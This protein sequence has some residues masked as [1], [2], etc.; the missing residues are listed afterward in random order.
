MARF[1]NCSPPCFLFNTRQNEAQPY[2]FYYQPR[3]F[4]QTWRKQAKLREQIAV[5]IIQK[6]YII[7]VPGTVH[8]NKA[9]IKLVHLGF[10]RG[11]QIKQKQEGSTAISIAEAGGNEDI[12]RL[13]R[14]KASIYKADLTHHVTGSGLQLFEPHTF[15]IVP[16][17]ETI[18]TT[19]TETAGHSGTSKRKTTT[20]TKITTRHYAVQ[21]EPGT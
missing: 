16:E 21:G 17:E 12:I 13:I 6:S 15:Q 7:I 18:T 2:D 3:K 14:E 9:K 19:T 20:T 5:E 4:V 1:S 8:L 11:E 10:K